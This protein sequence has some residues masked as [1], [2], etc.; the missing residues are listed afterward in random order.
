[1]LHRIPFTVTQ[2]Q[3]DDMD[4]FRVRLRFDDA[5]IVY[6]NGTEV[7]RKMVPRGSRRRGIRR[8]WRPIPT[9]PRFSSKPS[10]SANFLNLVKVG[11][12]V[13]AIHG[14]NSTTANS[15]FLVSPMLEYDT[16]SNSPE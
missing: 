7:G 4:S 2:Q 9:R 6:L 1:M 10:T 8:R 3:K 15:D 14:M 16:L 12:N 13:I 11:N 5:L